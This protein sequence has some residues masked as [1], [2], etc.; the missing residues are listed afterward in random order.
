MFFYCL[1]TQ[2]LTE[3]SGIRLFS[4]SVIS[5]SM[6]QQRLVFCHIRLKITLKKNKKKN[7]NS[8]NF[9]TIRRFRKKNG[10]FMEARPKGPSAF[11][12]PG[13]KKKR[14]VENGGSKY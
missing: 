13:G 7:K 10:S 5:R 14:V 9:A 3:I 1:F 12:T 8:S 6:K 4:V 11:A 2:I